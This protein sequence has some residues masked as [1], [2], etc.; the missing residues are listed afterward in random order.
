MRNFDSLSF[1]ENYTYLGP[2]GPELEKDALTLRLWAPFAERVV[3]RLYKAAF[4]PNPFVLLDLTPTKM[5]AW[6]GRIPQDCT[7]LYYTLETTYGGKPGG[8]AVDP[9]AISVAPNGRRG[10]LVDIEKTEPEGWNS[11]SPPPFLHVNDAFI[12]ELHVRDLSSN[13]SLNIQHKGKFLGLSELGTRT[14]S[15]IS[16][17]LDHLKDLGITHLHLLPVFD[18]DETDDLNYNPEEYNWGYNPRHFN[19]LKGAYSSNPENPEQAII[20]FRTAIM[21]LHKAGIR[22]VMDV[23]YNH[24]YSIENSHYHRLVPDYYHRKYGEIFSNGSGC[25]NEL[26]SERPMVRRMIIDSLLHWAKTFHIRGFRFDLMALID[27]ITINSAVQELKKLDPGF[28]IFGEGWTGGLSSLPDEKKCLKANAQKTREVAYFS[29]DTRDSIKGHVF[30][31][32]I[33]GFINGGEGMEEPIKFAMVACTEHPQVDLG[34]LIYAKQ[35]WATGP[36]QTISYFA[37]HDNHTLFD[38][39]QLTNPDANLLEL[40][41]L[42]KFAGAI[43]MTLQGIPFLHAGEEFMRHKKGEENSYRSPDSINGINWILKEQHMDVFEYFK[44]LVSF[45]KAHSALRLRSG[46]AIRNHLSFLDQGEQ[47]LIVTLLSDHAG[48]DLFEKI[49][50]IYNANTSSREVYLPVGDWSIYINHE[51]AGTKIIGTPKN[52]IVQVESQS[53][54]ALGLG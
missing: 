41:R 9:Y 26:A 14:K 30:I 17:G 49:L 23:V 2:L 24:T 46:D 54:M 7:G 28:L 45:R 20:D 43:V 39:L 5:G 38:K 34:Q 50:I 32:D 29:D 25:G 22:V 15:G 18:F 4:E 12:Y 52:G 10:Y 44:G 27:T 36:H 33:K 48:G 3:A 37:A 53:V 35:A 16:T 6:S 1:I 21:E 11:D 8:E 40:K 51:S 47:R 19:A 42:Q 31:G 13:P